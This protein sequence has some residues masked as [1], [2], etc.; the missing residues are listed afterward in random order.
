MDKM[1]DKK[2]ADKVK[3]KR[4]K[5]YKRHAKFVKEKHVPLKR[6]VNEQGEEEWVKD[7][8]LQEHLAKKKQ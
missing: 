3:K 8:S 5:R 6:V 4:D 7:I 1:I 2:K